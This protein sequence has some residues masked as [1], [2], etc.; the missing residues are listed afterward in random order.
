MAQKRSLGRKILIAMIAVVLGMLLIFGSIFALTMNNISSTLIKSNQELSEMTGQMSSSSMAELTEK[1]LLEL[2][3]EK[4]EIADGKFSDF[5]RAVSVV[6]TAVEQVYDDPDDY[7]AKSVSLPDPDNE[8]TLS[9]QVLYSAGTD[10]NDPRIVEELGLLG[11]VQDTLMAV[12]SSL[13]SLASVYFAAESGVMVQADYISAKKY[14]A[15]GRLM[16]LEAKERPWYQGAADTGEPFLT[17]VTRDVHTPRLAIMCGVPVYNKGQLMGVAGGGMYL[18]DM[19]ALVKS[20]DLGTGGKACIINKDGQVLFSTA[21]EGI[22]AAKENGPDLRQSDD[23]ELADMAKKAADGERGVTLVTMGEIPYY[24]AYAPLKTV[25]WSLLAIMPQRVVEAPT[26]KL[27]TNL[28]TMTDKALQDSQKQ[29]RQALYLLLALSGASLIIVGLLSLLLSRQIVKPIRMLTEEVSSMEGD[30]LDFRWEHNTGDE[31]QM[32]A[33]SFQ[34]LT[35]RMKDYISDIRAITA[36]RERIGT[37][38]DLARRIQ[39]SMLPSVFPAF[40]DRSEFDLYAAMDPAR[41]VGGDFYDFFLIDEDHLCLVIADVSGKGVPGAL[42]MMASKIILQGSAK[43]SKSPSEILTETNATIA[44]N[45]R[46]EMFVTAWV[47]ILELSTGK[48]TAANAGHEYPAL[49]GPKGEFALL[50]DKHGFVIGGFEGVKYTEYELQM[51][52]GAKLFLY[53]DGLPEAERGGDNA[54]MFGIERMLDALN[55]DPQ[56]TPR[57]ILE[58]MREAVADFVQDA[59][60]FDDLTML[61][62]EYKGNGRADID[63]V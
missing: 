46:E 33:N 32:L 53:T 59:E 10:P 57:Q 30:N 11:N 23:K 41:E 34:S 5:K 3:S 27:L 7:V 9:T 40:P 25:G 43:S 8:G 24:V 26:K 20:M 51:E 18:D 38:L 56:T 62:V 2:A 37:E 45:N 36:E 47:G 17:P 22:F 28:N 63:R 15:E 39:E 1:R 52:P 19:V 6:A 54:E 35:E 42:F 29:T 31:T 44:A 60:Q 55:D 48:L 61:C 16:P 14:D 50:K 13:E 49:R 4:A 12:N 21:E 58:H